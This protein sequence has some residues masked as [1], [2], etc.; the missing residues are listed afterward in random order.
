M[1][2]WNAEKAKAL[3]AELLSL[4]ERVKVGVMGRA[5]DGLVVD[6]LGVAA[7]MIQTQRLLLEGSR[8]LARNDAAVV[9]T[10]RRIVEQSSDAAQRLGASHEETGRRH[11]WYGTTLDEAVSAAAIALGLATPGTCPHI[12]GPRD[13]RCECPDCLGYGR[14]PCPSCEHQG[15]GDPDEWPDDL[16]VR[17]FP[18]PPDYP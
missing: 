6:A 16:R 2:D 5:G 3:E 15:G 7:N 12:P 10:A 1:S 18:Q 11:W 4:R 13:P 9:T 17:E 8:Q 14:H